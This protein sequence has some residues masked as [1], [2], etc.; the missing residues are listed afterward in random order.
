MAGRGTGTELLSALIGLADQV[1]GSGANGLDAKCGDA[2]SVSL[3]WA[4]D[5]STPLALPL[6]SKRARKA[7]STTLMERFLCTGGAKG[8]SPGRAVSRWQ[9]PLFS[10]AFFPL[11]SIL[12][13]EGVL[14]KGT[15]K[16]GVKERAL[17]FESQ[18]LRYSHH[19]LYL[20]GFQEA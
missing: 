2:L 4:L 8:G 16:W 14:G 7:P 13:V 3:Q 12:R 18:C 9:P 20:E 17:T 15:G 6:G 19:L 1:P 10:E 5:S 11:G